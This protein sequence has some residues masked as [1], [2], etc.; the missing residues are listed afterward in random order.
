MQRVF[1]AGPRAVQPC[2]VRIVKGLLGLDERRY[3]KNTLADQCLQK[4]NHTSILRVELVRIGILLLLE[5]RNGWYTC[6]VQNSQHT[7]GGWRKV[8]RRHGTL[9]P[10]DGRHV[11]LKPFLDIADYLTRRRCA[12]VLFG[13]FDCIF[14]AIVDVSLERGCEIFYFSAG[15]MIE[16][17]G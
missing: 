2:E 11:T 6:P 3:L 14:K 13:K 1:R 5:E 16:G 7:N 10:K 8:A 17:R 4:A 12:G 9:D 15:V